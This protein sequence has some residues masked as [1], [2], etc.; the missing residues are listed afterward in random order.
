MSK[1]IGSEP[2]SSTQTPEEVNSLL[3]VHFHIATK[4]HSHNDLKVSEALIA[5]NKVLDIR[6]L[7]GKTLLFIQVR[8]VRVEDEERCGGLFIS[9]KG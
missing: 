2:L 8:G 3:A 4:N 6:E 7:K 5:L 9:G 1:V